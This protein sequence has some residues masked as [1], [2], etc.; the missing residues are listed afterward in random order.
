MRK[1]R[2]YYT[3]INL[4]EIYMH[5]LEDFL[6]SKEG[7]LLSMEERRG[8]LREI[9]LMS[10]SI[11]IYD[12]LVGGRGN[13]ILAWKVG[14]ESK[15]RLFGNIHVAAASTGIR[16]REIHRV[17]AG[18]RRATSG[19]RFCRKEFDA[20]SFLKMSNMDKKIFQIDCN[21]V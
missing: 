6:T 18:E 21:E 1:S 9:G 10:L 8:I 19:Y 13:P 2:I 11:S 20:E 15:R 12:S 4:C 3:D 17:C 7:E 14:E 16:K 5:N